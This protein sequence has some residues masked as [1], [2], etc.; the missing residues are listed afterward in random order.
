MEEY[1]Y[2]LIKLTSVATLVLFF[3]LV[4][5]E[6]SRS[7]RFNSFIWLFFGLA[8]MIM[9]FFTNS[10]TIHNS[11]ML[12]FL[13]P[14]LTCFI[15]FLGPAYYFGIK[16]VQPKSLALGLFHSAFGALFLLGSIYHGFIQDVQTFHFEDLWTQ[17][18]HLL[19]LDHFSFTSKPLHILLA[20]I[21]F[22]FYFVNA[23]DERV[24]ASGKWFGI[25]ILIALVLMNFIFSGQWTNHWFWI[26]LIINNI[27]LITSGFFYVLKHPLSKYEI[28][29]IERGQLPEN[30]KLIQKFI[31]NEDGPFLQTITS[32]GVSIVDLVKVSNISLEDWAV[33]L[34]WRELDFINFKRYHRVQQAKKLVQEGYLKQFSVNGLTE[35]IGYQSR[36]SFYSAFKQIEGTSFTDYRKSIED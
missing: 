10:M 24:P 31:A 25:A 34:A 36:T 15:M 22:A 7:T 18:K 1:L 27:L 13:F 35:V 2:A 3:F 19:D 12:A 29:A 20:P 32:K 33:Y 11:R 17:D 28:V 21:H 9:V 23:Q 26:T 30:Y 14:E 16:N 5:G 4:G 6:K 8:M